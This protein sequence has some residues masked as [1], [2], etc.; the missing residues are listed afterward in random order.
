MA[1]PVKPDEI[2]A[3]LPAANSGICGKL[4]AALVKF[5][6]LFYRWYSWAYKSDGTPSDEFKDSIGVTVGQL[7]APTGVT[8]GDGTFEDKVVVNWNTVSGATYYEIWRAASNDSTAAT[9]IG[10]SETPS[11]TDESVT[12]DTTYWFFVKAKNATDEGG[13]SVGDSGFADSTGSGGTG[14]SGAITLFSNDTWTVPSGVT[15]VQ[16]EVWGASG[17]GGGSNCNWCSAGSAYYSG[18]GGGSG[19]YLKVT[20]IAVSTGQVLT[21]AGGV[22]GSKGNNTNSGSAGQDTVLRRSGTDLVIAHGGQGGGLGNYSQTGAGGSGGTGGTAPGGTIDTQTPGNA[23]ASGTRA[24][25]VP[26][27]GTGGAA[28]ASGPGPGGNGGSNSSGQDGA[29]GQIKLTWPSP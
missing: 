14:S 4:L 15:S 28:I 29:R 17:G 2:K 16:A 25:P 23:G 13:F 22:G 20:D 7:T 27:G 10:T 19:E 11:Y 1:N 24:Y 5:P 9:K 8:A 12:A 6:T 26:G 21:V 18:G 3:I